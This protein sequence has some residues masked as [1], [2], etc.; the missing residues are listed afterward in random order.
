M[1]MYILEHHMQRLI[2]IL[3]LFVGSVAMSLI[4]AF[5]VH[6]F[7]ATDASQCP[8]GTVFH[9]INPNLPDRGGTC[10]ASISSDQ[11]QQILTK[12]KTP[13]GGY[14][15]CNADG[16]CNPETADA[17]TAMNYFNGGSTYNQQ[18][19][20]ANA[21]LKLTDPRCTV[22]WSNMSAIVDAYCWGRIVGSVV[23]GA[24]V[25]ISSWFLTIA[26]VFF[27]WT[28]NYTVV[29]FGQFMTS[30]VLGGVKTAWT[31][32][33]DIANIIIIGMFTFIAVSI[34][35]GLKEYG[36]KRLI[37]HVLV[38]AV[39]INFSLL[40]TQM[41]I[42]ASNFVS[43]QFYNAALNQFAGAGAANNT[44]LSQNGVGNCPDKSLKSTC[45]GIAGA[46]M[47]YAGVSSYADTSQAMSN[48]AAKHDS[49]LLALLFATF[50]SLLFFGAAIVLFYGAFLL[51]SRA[52]LFIFLMTVSS[53]AFASYLVPGWDT[54]KYGFGSWKKSLLNNAILAPLMIMFL[55]MTLN[56]AKAMTTSG[57]GGSTLGKLLTDP[58]A[59]MSILF[60]FVVILGLLYASFRLS[61][62]L[63]GKVGGLESAFSVFGTLLAPL[64]LG[65][66][67]AAP[68]G[69]QIFGRA[70][71]RQALDLGNQFDKAKAEMQRTGNWDLNKLE[72]LNRAKQK[73]D[74]R[75][76]SSYN[77]MNTS[78]AKSIT[79]KLRVPKAL[80]GS[81]KKAVGYIDSAKAQAEKAAKEAA[82]MGM[83]DDAKKAIREQ[84]IDTEK[85]R[86]TERKE[87][88]ALE[89]R[90][91]EETI[92]T[93][94]EATRS[95]T[96]SLKT[97]QDQAEAVKKAIN[98]SYDKLEA[99]IAKEIAD[100][101]TGSPE[102]SAAEE[103]FAKARADRQNAIKE[104]DDKISNV[105][106][107]IRE[108]KSTS[109]ITELEGKIKDIDDKVEAEK[110]D[111]K[112]EGAET[113]RAAKQ[114][115]RDAEELNQ[116]NA[117]TLGARLSYGKY[118]SAFMKAT[119]I[120]PAEDTVAGRIAFGQT[121]KK[122]KIKSRLEL[123]KA[124]KDEEESVEPGEQKH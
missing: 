95:Q 118:S 33:R 97:Q 102:H 25:Y 91:H 46:F 48:I 15:M 78:L 37:A 105:N 63:A 24:A 53:L 109:G 6:T 22:T 104:Q 44:S 93:L 116:K 3:T 86:R 18:E 47:D 16:S 75:S 1:S 10:D 19:A 85:T 56:I 72:S 60:N 41:I 32:F 54:S 28:L 114:A 4:F 13:N 58:T 115:L 7:A 98:Q 73:A 96:D 122:L 82:G 79:S 59:N 108:I 30:T 107:Q 88:L 5:P 40:F 36:Q 124:E 69:R 31:A 55:W 61:S 68:F 92:K 83:S 8:P 65:S 38:I 45:Y 50:T 71:A 20:A 23:G 113:E 117:A 103:R 121:K 123:R 81:D 34:I 12:F 9:Y 62:S 39:L 111:K 52:I 110:L 35:L 26:G 87:E 21:Q 80:D 27:N 99:G 119:G 67:L 49:G 84:A 120:N 70:A 89:K 64:T 77:M 101:T 2:T 100:A 76:K 29:Q 106:E 42:D 14:L 66:Q 43:L 74:A 11:Q 51:A 17:A 112:F 57:N 94:Q 90:Q